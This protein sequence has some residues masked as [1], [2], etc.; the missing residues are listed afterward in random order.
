MT[1]ILWCIECEEDV[2]VGDGVEGH[3]HYVAVD[4]W[5]CDVEFCEGPFTYCQ[6]PV[7]L[8]DEDNWEMVDEPIQEELAIMNLHAEELYQDFEYEDLK[9]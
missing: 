7:S 5:E 3:T 6:P 8:F 2:I 9:F 1:Q 4:G